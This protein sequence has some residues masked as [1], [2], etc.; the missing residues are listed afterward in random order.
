MN[1]SLS[2]LALDRFLLFSEFSSRTIK[3]LSLDVPEK[4]HETLNIHAMN[5]TNPYGLH[6]D[7]VEDKIYFSDATKDRIMRCRPSGDPVE[8]IIDEVLSGVT[9]LALDIIGRKLYFC[10]VNLHS[11]EVADLDGSNRLHLINNANR[12]WSLELAYRRR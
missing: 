9:G 5:L 12:P 6:Y 3:R 10:D 2:P 4:L 1:V 11:I 8:V 7:P